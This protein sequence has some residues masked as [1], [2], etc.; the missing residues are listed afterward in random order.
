M[1]ILVTLTAATMAI[2]REKNERRDANKYD[3]AEGRI[4]ILSCRR[5]LTNSLALP[6]KENR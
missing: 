3:T 5:S 1:I 4:Y 2:Q 6:I